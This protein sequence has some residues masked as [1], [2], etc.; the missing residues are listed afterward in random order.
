MTQQSSDFLVVPVVVLFISTWKGKGEEE[1]HKAQTRRLQHLSA[2][3]GQ[4]VTLEKLKHISYSA[5]A[6]EH[7]MILL[8]VSSLAS[9]NELAF[10]DKSEG[11]TPC[12]FV[13]RLP[14]VIARYTSDKISQQ[15]KSAHC[16]VLL[17]MSTIK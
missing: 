16:D 5:C 10:L 1:G 7:C 3:S 9:T 11:V 6:S 4:T 2:D 12:P 15:I 14:W 8:T 17:F 13:F